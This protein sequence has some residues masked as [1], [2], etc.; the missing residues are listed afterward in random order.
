[1]T[2]TIS[3]L[4]AIFGS[5]ENIPNAELYELLCLPETQKDL[6]ILARS[7]S[8]ETLRSDAE[9]RLSEFK[10]HSFVESVR[11]KFVTDSR[12]SAEMPA[13]LR[14]LVV[15]LFFPEYTDPATVNT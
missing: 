5:Y 7:Y 2:K 9:A 6:G 11:R 14:A 10:S 3:E 4:K 13:E 12:F 8:S 1:M 15:G